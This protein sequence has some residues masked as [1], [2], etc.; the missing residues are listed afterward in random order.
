[1]PSC[2]FLAN[3]IL[4][5]AKGWILVARNTELGKRFGTYGIE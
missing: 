1:M 5:Q 2:V 3:A 4:E